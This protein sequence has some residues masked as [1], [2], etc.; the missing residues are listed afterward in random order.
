FGLTRLAHGRTAV[1]HA[2][3]LARLH[4][5]GERLNQVLLGDAGAHLGDGAVIVVPPGRLHPVPWA[6]LPD[7]ADRVLSIAPSAASWLRARRAGRSP[8][9]S[10][11]VLVRGPGLQSGG[12]EVEELARLYAAENVH[13]LGWGSAAADRVLNALDG[14]RLAHVAAHGTFR[15]DSP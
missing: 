13:V 10:R 2:E 7:L 11:I 14:A 15:A 3:L 1:P 12:A 6:L 9:G 5:L 8:Q 4:A